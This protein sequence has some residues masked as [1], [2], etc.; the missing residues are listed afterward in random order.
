M[1]LLNDC[2]KSFEH[3]YICNSNKIFSLYPN[4]SIVTCKSCKF[5]FYKYLP[6]QADLDS[7]YGNYSRDS[8]IT[9]SSHQ[10]LLETVEDILSKGDIKSAL[11]IACGECY[12]LDALNEI[13]PEIDLYAS[14]HK[15]AKANVISKGYKFLEGE[16]YPKT[17]LKFDLIVFTEAIEHINDPLDFL[18]HAN[19]L[20]AENGMLY[21]TTPCFSSLERKIM[22]DRWGMIAPPEHLSYF[23]KLSMDKA[24]QLTGFKKVYSRTLNISIFR[25]IEFINS[26]KQ[27]GISIDHPN[28]VNYMNPQKYA[29]RAQS[30]VSNNKFLLISKKIIN[31]FL[32]LSGLGSSLQVLYKKI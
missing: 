2:Q 24:M 26:N 8:F 9:E 15:S 13:N 30:I 18:K 29:D 28:K 5:A 16:F 12:F 17:D 22:K 6:L 7:I 10:K 23:S 14:E 20:L 11:D 3:C 32:D 19:N 1:K 31:A 21:M 25:I 4:K 27:N